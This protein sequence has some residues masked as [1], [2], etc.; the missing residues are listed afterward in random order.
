MDYSKILIATD[1]SECSMRAVEKG[2]G[3]AKALSSVV[4]ILHVMDMDELVK[5]IDLGTVRSKNKNKIDA[6][7]AQKGNV[8]FDSVLKDYPYDKITRVTVEGYAKDTIN[9]IAEN[10][11]VNLIIM[12]THGRTGLR[13]L[14]M[15]SVAEHVIRNSK[16]PV[17]V[18][19]SYHK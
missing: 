12:G 1:G 17:M 11:E 15:G 8:I 9:Q 16:I 4:I 2:I 3:L 5:S 14:I 13:H 7:I 6:V 19:H 18:V 10:H